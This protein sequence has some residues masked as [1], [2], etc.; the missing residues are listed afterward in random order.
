MYVGSSYVPG[1]QV[2][3]DASG[4][5]YNAQ[6]YNG[7][8]NLMLYLFNLYSNT[9]TYT[10]PSTAHST[11]LNVPAYLPYLGQAFYVNT[12]Y[13]P[14]YVTLNPY[15]YGGSTPV[16]AMGNIVVEPSGYASTTISTPR[17]FTRLLLYCHMPT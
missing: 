7:P 10:I 5:G 3:I 8:N 13:T 17:L 11:T 2:W 6:G 9:Y 14:I 1:S 16:S 12:T 4:H 15:V